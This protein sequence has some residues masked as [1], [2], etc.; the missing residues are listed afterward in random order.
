VAEVIEAEGGELRFPEYER[1]PVLR[2]RRGQLAGG[3]QQM[4]AISRGLMWRPKLI[5]MDEPTL[6]LSP[7]LVDQMFELI[8]DLHNAGQAI[9][10][11]EQNATRAL[12]ISQR[13]Y[14]LV[15]GEVVVSGPASALLSDP[16]LQ[17]SYLG[18]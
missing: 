2:E 13:A 11:V 5:L 8:H 4:L 16:Q 17:R 6:G 1:F 14:V 3:Q 9:L 7:L 18:G 15:S 10:L 12:A